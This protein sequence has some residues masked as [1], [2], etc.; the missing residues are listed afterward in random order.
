MYSLLP[1]HPHASKIVATSGHGSGKENPAA[2][3]LISGGAALVFEAGMGHYIEFLKVLKQTNPTQSYAQL[4]QGITKSKG[5]V[6]IWDGFVPWGAIQAVAKGSVFGLGHVLAI[7]FFQPYVERG[8]LSKDV[9][10][11]LAG[12]IGGGFQGFVLSPTLLLKTRVMTNPIFREKMSLGETT[13]QSLSVG[14]KVIREEGI[15]ALMKGSVVFSAKRVADWSTRFLFTVMAENVVFKRGNKDYKLTR[16]EQIMSG[17]L[18][19]FGSTICTLP[20]DV[21]VAQIQQA[22]KA[23]Q[24]VPLLELF[25][26]QYKQGGMKQLTGMA[27]RGFVARLAHVALTTALMK[28]ATSMIYDS[29][30]GDKK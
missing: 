9:A 3:F 13:Q 12:G 25:L 1:I 19:G 27:T 18:G 24:K 17:L 6:G 29:I 2:K 26:E 15:Q 30:Y 7:N 22:S 28:T 5:L 20:L 11:I 21:A 10:D 8:S 14:M 23:G 16:S 4:T